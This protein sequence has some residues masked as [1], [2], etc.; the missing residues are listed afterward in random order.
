MAYTSR[1][2]FA[3]KLNAS[4]YRRTPYRRGKSCMPVS[5]FAYDPGSQFDIY[6]RLYIAHHKFPIP[7]PPL[8]TCARFRLG[9]ALSCPHNMRE[10]RSETEPKPS[11]SIRE[12]MLECWVAAH[13]IGT[14]CEMG[15][16]ARNEGLEHHLTISPPHHLTP[17][18]GGS[19]SSGYK[20]RLNML[21]IKNFFTDS[22]VFLECAFELK[23][24][25]LAYI[26][27]R[28]TV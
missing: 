28:L 22:E 23:A 25:Y 8:D 20:L 26:D 15:C 13:E 17:L 19:A 4:L 16:C 1:F 6:R 27:S 9:F 12:G 18:G 10:L 5:Q 2:L 7:P 14:A 11:A 24:G 21:G 3:F